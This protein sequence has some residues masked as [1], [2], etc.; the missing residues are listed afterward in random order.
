MLSIKDRQAAGH[1][2]ALLA[3]LARLDTATDCTTRGRHVG[4]CKGQWACVIIKLNQKN[5]CWTWVAGLLHLLLECSRGVPYASKHILTTCF[6][7]QTSSKR[8]RGNSFPY[9]IGNQVCLVWARIW[10]FPPCVWRN[11]WGTGVLVKVLVKGEEVSTSSD[12]QARD[13]NSE[14]F[15]APDSN[16]GLNSIDWVVKNSNQQAA[17]CKQRTHYFR[18]N[19]MRFIMIIA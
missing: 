14:S 9:P 8:T 6:V 4:M 2:H 13:S 1:L 11:T 17:Y 10:P 7:A 3:A 19:R 16:S 5:D 12:F 15:Q 18:K